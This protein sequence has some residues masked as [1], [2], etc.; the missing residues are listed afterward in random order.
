[1]RA[2]PGARVTIR[3]LVVR[4]AGGAP[5]ELTPD[6]LADTAGGAAELA[7]LRGYEYERREVR[8]I[9]FDEPGVFDVDE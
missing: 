3:R 8:E 1:M 9:V 4:N 2:V 5:R 7:R 6:E